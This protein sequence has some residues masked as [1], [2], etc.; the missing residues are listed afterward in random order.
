MQCLRDGEVVSVV[1]ARRDAHQMLAR[2]MLRLS[3]GAHRLGA[4]QR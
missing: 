1:F 4:S 3:L 2:C